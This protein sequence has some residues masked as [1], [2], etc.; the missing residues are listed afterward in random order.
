LGHYAGQCSD[1][2]K[3]KH[4][5]TAAT[6]EEEEFASQFERECSL[7]VC[8]SIVETPSRIRY[9]DSRASNHMSGVKEHFTD[10]KDPE[11]RLE[12]VLGDNTIVRVV[13]RGTVSFQ[14][15]LRPPLV[16]K[17]VLYV[18]GL[19]KNL[20]SVSSIQDKGFEVSFRET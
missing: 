6:T 5:G 11:I 2:K 10:L 15:E 3:K 13:G 7:I 16:F 20:I 4:G 14:R 1:K 18:P 8:C 19:K 12:I 9:I 17:D